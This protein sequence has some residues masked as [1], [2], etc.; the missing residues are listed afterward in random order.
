MAE[1]DHVWL[2][3]THGDGG[4]Q[5]GQ[6]AGLRG[7]AHR[8]HRGGHQG[9]H[10]CCQGGD[11]WKDR[12]QGLQRLLKKKRTLLLPMLT[13]VE[14]VDELELLTTLVL[15]EMEVETYPV[16]VEQVI[17]A[18]TLLAPRLSRDCCLLLLLVEASMTRP[19]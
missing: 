1:Y 18:F 14:E 17:T 16:K 4:L 6:A 19:T 2:Q 11:A 9:R 10:R 8:V 5:G 13:V 7:R 15:E 3:S 12:T